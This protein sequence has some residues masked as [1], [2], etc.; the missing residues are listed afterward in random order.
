MTTDRPRA[1]EFALDDRPPPGYERRVVSREHAVDDAPPPRHKTRR[2]DREAL[3]RG[4]TP[5]LDG[6]RT[7]S[8]AGHTPDTLL[9]SLGLQTR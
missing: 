6:K 4:G 2:I 1:R 5:K 3:S 8:L 9:A 7:R